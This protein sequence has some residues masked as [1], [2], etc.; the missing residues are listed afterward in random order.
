MGR[1]AFL[2][3]VFL[4]FCALFY[5]SI[6]SVLPDRGAILHFISLICRISA[7]LYAIFFDLGTFRCHF[8]YLLLYLLNTCYLY[9]IRKS[10]LLCGTSYKYKYAQIVEKQQLVFLA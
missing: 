7:I 6:V 1:G 10:S 5:D 4:F 3:N 8:L 9:I 2:F